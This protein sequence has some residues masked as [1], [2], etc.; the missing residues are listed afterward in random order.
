MI[1]LIF[2]DREDPKEQEIKLNLWPKLK[3]NL[4]I[5]TCYIVNCVHAIFITYP[6]IAHSFISISNL[7]DCFHA[8][9]L[10]Q[11]LILLTVLALLLYID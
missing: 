5:L 10:F 2:H 9:I 3:T 7:T 11:I 4:Q 6:D 1:F 8:I